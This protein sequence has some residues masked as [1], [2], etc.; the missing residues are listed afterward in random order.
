MKKRSS[1]P[2]KKTKVDG[3][4]FKSKL[5]ALTYRLLKEANVPSEYEQRSY[6]LIEGFKP[7]TECWE[8]RYDRFM[9]R[10]TKISSISYTPD[11]TCPNGTWVI[12]AKGR[13]NESFPIRWKLFRRHVEQYF[14]IPV[15]FLVTNEK[16]IRMAIERIKTLKNDE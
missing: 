3:I 4:T 16:D 2:A 10:E 14:P 7:K 9:L 11:F 6:E 1:I 5:E 13:A 12:E 15:L 8:H